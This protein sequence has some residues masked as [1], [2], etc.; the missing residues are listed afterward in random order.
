MTAPVP[1][2]D[3]IWIR[4]DVESIGVR[5]LGNDFVLRAGNHLVYLAPRFQ[6]QS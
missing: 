2:N 5:A 6:Y 3:V 4:L 1:N